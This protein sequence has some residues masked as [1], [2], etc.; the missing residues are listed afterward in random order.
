LFTK[1]ANEAVASTVEISSL[2]IF[3]FDFSSIV[4][5]FKFLNFDAHLGRVRFIKRGIWRERTRLILVRM[6]IFQ[7]E[8]SEDNGLD[9]FSIAEL[10]RRGF[11]RGVLK[12][13]GG[14]ALTLVS[15]ERKGG[16]GGDGHVVRVGDGVGA[17]VVVNMSDDRHNR[18]ESE[19]AGK[20]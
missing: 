18:L 2:L 13:G 14:C 11:F 9:R 10:Y 17:G 3:G 19:E 15:D 12:V 16:G 4:V 6:L 8:G 7:L 20:L 5:V 1:L